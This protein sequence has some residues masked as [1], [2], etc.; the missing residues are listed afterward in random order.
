MVGNEKARGAGHAEDL[1]SMVTEVAA[2]YVAR[3]AALDIGK[4]ELTACVRVPAAGQRSGGRRQQMVR[5]YPTLAPDLLGLSDWLRVERVELV[6]MEATGDY[7]KPVYYLLEAEGH[8]VWLCNPKHVKNVPGRPKT[9]RLDAVWLAKVV[10][11]GMCGPSLVHPKPIRQLQDL[12]RYRRSLVRERTREKQRLEK[13]LEDSQV[14]LSSV[15]SDVLGVSGRAMLEAL[16]AGQRDPKVLAQMARGSMRGKVGV[17]EQALTG[18]FEDHHARLARRMLDRIDALSLDIAGLDAEI[19]A[20]VAPFQDLIDLLN[21]IPGV[22][23]RSA[24]ELIA[25]IGIDMTRFPT[26]AHL[27]SWAKFA[28][29]AKTSAGR[30]THGGKTGK[31]NPW[32][33]G[34]LGEIVAGAG[35]THTFL[36]ARYRRLASRRGKDR[37]I[38]AVGNSVLKS[39]W[40]LLSNPDQSYNELGEGW[41]ENRRNHARRKAELIRQLQS[42]TGQQVFL[43]PA[44]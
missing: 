4:A 28:P 42:L 16:I 44:S 1:D 35:K 43:Q 34:T 25:E 29:I 20:V 8:R 23:A 40:H 2:E 24:Q 11:R 36:G 14:K 15:I 21:Q 13:L 32:L 19:E 41:Y 10:E 31:G 6:A 5:A 7:W 22:N 12:T 3:V 26:P 18:H 37:A 27:V 30:G 9:D 39:V 17:L 38:V 33:A